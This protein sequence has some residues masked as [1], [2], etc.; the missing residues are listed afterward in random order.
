MRLRNGVP[1]P[2][3][4]AAGYALCRAAPAQ[5]PE[6]QH[7]EIEQPTCAV[8]ET[9]NSQVAPRLKSQTARLHHH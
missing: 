4:L 3:E 1:C 8:I 7:G 2:T 6:S 9:A 5:P